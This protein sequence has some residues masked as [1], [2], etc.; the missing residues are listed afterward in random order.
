PGAERDV[1]VLSLLEAGFPD[2][3]GEDGRA[4]ELLVGEVLALEGVL[5]QLAALGLEVFL[6]LAGEELADLVAG[7]RRGDER[8]PVAGGAARGGLAGEDLDPVAAA[9]AVVER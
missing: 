8:Q 5:E 7:A 3:A 2:H 4:R 6:L 1:E 9:Q